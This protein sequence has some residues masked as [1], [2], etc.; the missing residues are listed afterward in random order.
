MHT[1][2][3]R[4]G[5]RVDLNFPFYFPIAKRLF[6]FFFMPNYASNDVNVNWVII[7]CFLGGRD[8]MSSIWVWDAIDKAT[9]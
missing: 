9:E 8:N 5:C 2:W 6:F 3:R 7:F 4:C 1:K